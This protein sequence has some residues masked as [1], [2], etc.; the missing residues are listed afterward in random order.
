MH[1]QHPNLP[2]LIR[3]LET[4]H[5][6]AERAQA[7]CEYRKALALRR[8]EL[9][10]VRKAKAAARAMKYAPDSEDGAADN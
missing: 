6:L 7:N 2:A 5:A 1:T 4:L 9:A 10:L 8:Q 3:R